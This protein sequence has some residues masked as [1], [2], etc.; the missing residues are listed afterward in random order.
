[1]KKVMHT[2]QLSEHI[3]IIDLQPLGIPN[4]I[5]SYVLR[6]NDST[7]IIETG[8]TCSINNLLSGLQ[9]LGVSEE[10]VEYVAVSHIHI[11]H[12]GGAGTLMQH[13]PNAKLL[14]HPKGAAHMVNPQRLWEASK[15]V[16]REVAIA[17]QEIQAVPE[18][19]VVTPS[20]GTVI[21]LGGNIKFN[22]LET[23]GHA[24]HHLGFFEPSSNGVFQGDAAGIYIP[25]LNVTIPTTP[26]PFQLDTTIASIQRIIEMSPARLYYTHFGPVENAVEH[27]NDYVAQLQLWEKTVAESMKMGDNPQT[28]YQKIL[29]S[30]PQMKKAEEFIRNHIVLRKGVVMQNIQGFVEYLKKK[31][32]L[33]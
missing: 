17:Y 24:S 26:A 5:A 27:L 20:D 3:Y 33:V 6:G 1:V 14:V 25:P 22:V 19:R 11:D 16:L 29:D 7:A 8:P 15:Q 12:A 18:N 2:R 28:M 32:S 21:D 13:L 30:D 23:L 31:N 10:D 9:E 4:F